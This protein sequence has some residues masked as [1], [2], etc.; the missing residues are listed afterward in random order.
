MPAKIRSSMREIVD[1]PCDEM[2]N[3][4]DRYVISLNPVTLLVESKYEVTNSGFYS[5]CEEYPAAARAAPMKHR[6]FVRLHFLYSNVVFPPVV[7]F[8][9]QG[10]MELVDGNIQ[11]RRGS[12]FRQTSVVNADTPGPPEQCPGA[13]PN[14]VNREYLLLST[15]DSRLIPPFFF[16]G[17]NERFGITAIRQINI[18]YGDETDGDADD[19]GTVD[20][21]DRRLVIQL[22]GADIDNDPQGRYEP[23]AD[24]DWSGVVDASDLVEFD[25]QYCT[26]DLSGNGSVDSAD[27]VLFGNYYSAGSMYA[28]FDGNSVLNVLDY[29]EFMNVAVGCP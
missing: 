16:P 4:D 11:N 14:T 1:Y 17:Y 29:I 9:F 28:D 26:A 19:S 15:M 12:L 24:L 3:I 23:R 8:G 21:L 10:S 25:A 27:Y 5:G 13:T 22:G 18:F 6:L 7:V 2:N 20:V